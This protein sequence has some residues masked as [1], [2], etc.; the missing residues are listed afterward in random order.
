[1]NMNDKFIELE[2]LPEGGLPE[3][4]LPEGTQVT[5]VTD[6]KTFTITEVLNTKEHDYCY[7][8]NDGGYDNHDDMK[9]YIDDLLFCIPSTVHCESCSFEVVPD[10]K[11][12]CSDCGVDLH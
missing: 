12:N 3:G 8:Y 2:T 1:M 7:I 6:E 11:G 10:E 4:G 9:E 5:Y